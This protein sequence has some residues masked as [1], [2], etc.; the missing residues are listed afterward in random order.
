ML[1]ETSSTNP[2]LLIF[3]EG[4]RKDQRRTAN[5]SEQIKS[6]SNRKRGKKYHQSKLTTSNNHINSNLQSNPSTIKSLNSSSSN[7]NLNQTLNSKIKN[8]PSLNQFEDLINR[9]KQTAN[10]INQPKT[11]SNKTSSDKLLKLS[12]Q[13]PIEIPHLSLK[14]QISV[15]IL[16]SSS[17]QTQSLPDPPPLTTSSLV[18][19]LSNPSNPSST[20]PADV[21]TVQNRLDWASL[22]EAAGKP[23]AVEDELPDLTEWAQDSITLVS[24]HNIEIKSEGT[25]IHPRG[26]SSSTPA[27]PHQEN[28]PIKIESSALTHDLKTL[29][30]TENLHPPPLHSRVL[31]RNSLV[32]KP[33]SST[34]NLSFTE[35]NNTSRNYSSRLSTKQKQSITK[36]IMPKS[37]QPPLQK[38]PL[39]SSTKTPDILQ[40]TSQTKQ[41]ALIK[42]NVTKKKVKNSK[43]KSNK[44]DDQEFSV[45]PNDATNRDETKEENQASK[46]DEK[47]EKQNGIQNDSKPQEMIDQNLRKTSTNGR[48]KR[49]A[50]NSNHVNVSIKKE[51]KIKDHQNKVNSNVISLNGPSVNLFGKLTH[52]VLQ[53]KSTTHAH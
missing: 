27:L 53:Q 48:R 35:T 16:S 24:N 11:I 29:K 13:T 34:T 46:V 30:L 49:K 25:K 23:D 26:L 6:I 14:K 36:L 9:L 32:V 47:L 28:L 39:V 20:P 41:A 42:D 12:D 31:N 4:S 22:V 2:E 17:S 18:V 5:P 33:L 52:G 38:S 15:G 40:S 3:D 1:K 43:K 44:A 45:T 7:Q 10:Q 37:P 8:S 19:K 51:E 50:R 21:P